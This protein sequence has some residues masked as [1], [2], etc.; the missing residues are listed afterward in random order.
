MQYFSVGGYITYCN[1]ISLFTEVCSALRS[2]GETSPRASL[3]QV[4]L[5]HQLM[6][7]WLITSQVRKDAAPLHL[8]YPDE[9]QVWLK[10]V[11]L[12]LSVPPT[13]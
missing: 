1:V 6:F 9:G 7:I 8:S 10:H 13:N 11:G 2:A 5:I 4:S 12:I 3:C